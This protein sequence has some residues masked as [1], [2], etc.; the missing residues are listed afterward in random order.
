MLD[1]AA[2]RA[3]YRLITYET[4]GSTNQDALARARAGEPGDVWIQ[5][6]TQTAGRGRK[7]RAWSSPPGNL[8]V[9]LLVLDPAEPQRSA[10]LGFVAGLALA[11]AVRRLSPPGRDVR[12]KWPNDLVC[13]GAKLAGIL[14]EGTQRRDGAFACAIG[15]GVNCASHPVDLAYPATDLSR[16]AE[17]SITAA[18]VLQELS[19][20]FV[21]ARD[22]WARGHG[23]SDIR[24]AWLP[25]ALPPGAAL[26]VKTQS[27]TASGEFRT[28]DERGR[29]VLDSNGRTMTIDAADVFLSGPALPRESR[30]GW[31]D[32]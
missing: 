24:R 15:F 22:L 32:E 30:E 19:A 17:R 8:Y 18:E 3:G 9:S 1:E 31:Y 16:I 14:I 2:I 26:T 11:R 6:Q 28:I 25:L 27:C 10:E 20:E 7:G 29:L 23:F 5:A 13:G 4:L 12:L 21:Q